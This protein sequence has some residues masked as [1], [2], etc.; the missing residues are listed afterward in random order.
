[1]ECLGM[2][3]GEEEEFVLETVHNPITGFIFQENIYKPV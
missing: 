1:M 3:M 2:E